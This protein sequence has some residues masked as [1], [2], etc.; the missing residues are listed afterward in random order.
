M[1]LKLRAARTK[2]GLTQ[3]QV[4]QEAEIAERLYQNYEYGKS[5]PC[6]RTAIKIADALNADVRELFSE[7]DEKKDNEN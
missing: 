1:N 4:A 7:V 5:E 3:K 6:V 2:L